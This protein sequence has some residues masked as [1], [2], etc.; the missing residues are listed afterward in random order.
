MFRLRH[1]LAVFAAVL[2][3]GAASRPAAAATLTSLTPGVYGPYDAGMQQWTED[4]DPVG[5]YRIPGA[6]GMAGAA[7]SSDGLLLTQAALVGSGPTLL[8][9][10]PGGTVVRRL[11]LPAGLNGGSGIAVSPADG[12][13]FA[14]VDTRLL[15]VAPDFSSS[16]ALPAVFGRAAGVALSRDGTLY[17]VDQSQ[18]RINVLTA[19]GTVGRTIPTGPTPIGLAFGPDGALYYTDTPVGGGPTGFLSRLVR[20]DVGAGD[21]QS[22]F[23]SGLPFMSAITF[24]PDGSYY[25]GLYGGNALAHYAFD[26]TLL[27]MVDSPGLT[28]GVAVV[29]PEPGCGALIGLVAAG[30]LVRRRPVRR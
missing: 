16:T 23:Q 6:S 12:T 14:A 18:R 11:P 5:T 26:G 28:D 10:G 1:A 9:V 2:L 22:V 20:V 25:L 7:V 8:A 3:C 15:R 19:Q 29:A 30:L 17:A 4:L 13:I 21:S 24:A 27:R